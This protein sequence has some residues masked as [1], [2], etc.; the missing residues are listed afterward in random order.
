M[1]WQKTTIIS[2]ANFAVL[3]T[4]VWLNY[5]GCW[6]TGTDGGQLIAL[7]RGPDCCLSVWI[8]HTPVTSINETNNH[9]S[10]HNSRRFQAFTAAWT[11]QASA[12]TACVKSVLTHSIK[13]MAYVNLVEKNLMPRELLDLL[14]GIVTMFSCRHRAIAMYFGDPPPLCNN[15]CD[16]CQDPTTVRRLSA[17]AKVGTAPSTSKNRH[18]VSRPQLNCVRVF[19]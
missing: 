17:E 9:C 3:T 15:S 2:T 19:H 10:L 8:I 13:N 5:V 16:F 12:N 14:P 7:L 18:S 1:Q 4:P 11:T 6:D